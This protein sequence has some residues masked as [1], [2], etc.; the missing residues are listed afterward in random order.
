MG[1][2]KVSGFPRKSLKVISLTQQAGQHPGKAH[3][4]SMS[5]ESFHQKPT[6][7]PKSPYKVKSQHSSFLTKYQLPVPV[8]FL[9]YLTTPWYHADSV[10]GKGPPGNI[11]IL[12]F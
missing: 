12:M 3:L 5:P 6:G 1:R 8:S 7:S 11:L 2:V 4:R 10:S 9:E